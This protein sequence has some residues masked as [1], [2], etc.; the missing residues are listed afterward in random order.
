MLAKQ[1]GKGKT[2]RV[3]FSLP[4]SVQGETAYLVGDFNHWDESANPMEQ[5]G[6][7]GF[8][9]RLDLEK[10]RE[11]QFRYLINNNE[12]HNDWQADQYVQNGY[13]GDNS[14]VST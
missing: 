6:N 5:D 4:P 11:Y 14:V 8:V 2:V 9:L 3:T 13:G 7:G 12:W 1:N 10:G